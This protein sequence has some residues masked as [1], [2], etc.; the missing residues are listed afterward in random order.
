MTNKR[1]IPLICA[2]S[3]AITPFCSPVLLADVD[4]EF[5]ASVVIFE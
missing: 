2:M 4:D 1:H 5:G 3:L